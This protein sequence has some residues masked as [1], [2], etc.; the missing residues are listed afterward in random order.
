MNEDVLQGEQQIV[1]DNGRKSPRSAGSPSSDGSTELRAA[2]V[3][4]SSSDTSDISS[5]DDDERFVD[6]L[7]PASRHFANDKDYLKFVSI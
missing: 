6:L 2:L 5:L 7:D 4:R 1:D 3:T